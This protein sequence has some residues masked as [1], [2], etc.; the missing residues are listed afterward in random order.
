VLPPDPRRLPAVIPPERLDA[1]QAGALGALLDGADVLAQGGPGSGRTALALAAALAR[2]DPEHTSSQADRGEDVLLLSPRRAAADPLRD[3]VALAGAAGPVRVATP[4]AFAFAVVRSVAG[5]RGRGEPTLVTGA[6]QDALLGD[7]IA[8]RSDWSLDVDAATRGLPGF[9]TELRDLVTRAQELGIGP[10]DLRELGLRRGRPA[11]LDAA[12][13]LREYLDVL[14][15]QGMTALDAGPRLDSGALVRRGAELV[16]SLTPRHLPATVVVDDA[17]DLTVAG[18]DLVAALAEAGSRVLV[19][20]CPDVMV[21][22]FRG[23]VADAGA[24]IAAALPRPVEAMLLGGAHRRGAPRSAVDALR[25]RLPLAGAPAASRRAPDA[26][27]P[28]PGPEG[29]ISVLTLADQ[30]EEARVIAGALRDLHHR[31]SVPYDEM[32]V[33]CRSGGAVREMADMLARLGLAVTTPQRLPALREVAVIADLLRIVELGVG[34]EP[35]Q[36]GTG[37][38]PRGTAA[39]L[40]VGEATQLLRGPFGDADD[41]RLRRIRRALLDARRREDAV[42]EDTADGL[43]ESTDGQIDDADAGES[44]EAG[45]ADADS[46]E[47]G[48]SEESSDSEDSSALLA[49]ALVADDAPGLEDGGRTAT[50][51]LRLRRMIRAVRDLGPTPAAA[52]ALWAAWDAARLAEGWQHAALGEDPEDADGARARLTA[53][54]LDAVSA[55]FAAVDRFTERRP[56]ADALVF[57]DQIRTQSVAEDTL[58]PRAEAAGRVAVLTPAQ[59]AGA[60]RDTVVLARLQE[61]TWPNV[62]LRSTLFGAAELSLLGGRPDGEELPLEPA[63]LRAVQRESVVVDEVRLAVSALTRARERVLITAVDGGELAPSVLVD[64]LGARAGEGW[65]ERSVITEDP[66][67]APDARR[68][69]AALRRRLSDPDPTV[70]ARAAA[71]LEQL[72][73]EGVAGTDPSAWYHQEPSSDEPV[74]MPGVPVRLSPSALERAHACP[75]AW[76]LERAGGSRPSGPAQLVGTAVHRLAQEHPAGVGP[77][78]VEDLVVRLQ[79]LL[80]PLHLT[81]TWS[82]R[83]IL[84]RA[85]DSARLLADYLQTAPPA[86]AVEAPFE[87]TLGN[88]VLRGAIDRIEG[89][90]GPGENLRIVDL[91]TGRAAKRAADVEEDLQLGAYQ[92]AVARGALE[93]RLGPQAPEHLAGAQLVYVGTGS[94]KP[95]LRLQGAPSAADDPAWFET[96][97]AGVAQEVGESRVTAR[98]NAHCD[99]CAVRRTCALWAEGEEL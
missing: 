36:E 58:A 37:T 68:L 59:L 26:A 16:A 24:R 28:G 6:E 9:R 13:I 14:D 23:A 73:A 33:V 70:R 10:S 40:S 12:E 65:L 94:A 38:D 98:R 57:I 82:G 60:E 45:D 19:T 53:Q 39:A 25:G 84:R 63:A 22:S 4:P 48:D 81:D 8:S 76:L 83:R 75:Q 56:Q 93:D 20:S 15:L 85:E 5:E 35:G 31:R 80:R 99:T 17:Q 43:E 47:P 90:T 79:T 87:Y 55:L 61:G 27:D 74:Q 1:D 69:V 32:A 64:L 96:V 95:V 66:G 88:V 62:R 18:I 67:P 30:E 89:G 29:G 91:K 97:V 77:D 2:T 21:D 49:R 54:R 72:R 92:T 11:W 52:D 51:V 42:R 34:P 41:L 71:L 3:A 78:Q 46:A 50:P 44:A 7:L 86:A